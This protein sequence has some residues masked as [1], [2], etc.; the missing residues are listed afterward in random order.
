MCIAPP[1]DDHNYGV[2]EIQLPWCSPVGKRKHSQSPVAYP[3]K[4]RV[5]TPVEDEVEKLKIVEGANA[6]LNLAGIKLEPSM[7]PI[8]SSR[9]ISPVLPSNIEVKSET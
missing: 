1:G 6:L 5:S 3:E 9:S 8:M 2:T 4:M 7:T